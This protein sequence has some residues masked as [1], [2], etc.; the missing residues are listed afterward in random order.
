MEP[1]SHLLP[2]VRRYAKKT[3]QI[4]GVGADTVAGAS[5]GVVQSEC[6]NAWESG[7]LGQS[8]T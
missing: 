2:A 4:R 5:R 1:F 6:A 3:A 8:M 7:F